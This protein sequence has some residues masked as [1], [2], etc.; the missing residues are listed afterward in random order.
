MPATLP[1]T[2]DAIVDLNHDKEIDM[3]KTVNDGI[4]A[5]IHKAS[6]MRRSKNPLISNAGKP[7]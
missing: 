6:E 1:D 5:V 7:H 3:M 2:I 4:I